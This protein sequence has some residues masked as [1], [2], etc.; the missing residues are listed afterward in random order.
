M[1]I[2]AWVPGPWEIAI[3]AVIALLL[4]GKRLPEI[5]KSLGRGIVEFKKGLNDVQNEVTRPVEDTK[6]DQSQP[7]TQS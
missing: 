3:V 4:F 2:L 5:G 6:D 7:P 1:Q